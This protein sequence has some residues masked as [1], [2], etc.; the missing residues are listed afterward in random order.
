MDQT[1]R[2]LI[3]LFKLWG[4][5]KFFHPYL[6]YRN[7][8]WDG[9]LI[10]AIPK[11]KAADDAHAFAEAVG[12]NGDVSSFV[13]PGGV[14]VRF[15]GQAVMHP[16]GRQLQR[17]GLLPD[18]EVHPTIQGLREG[19]DEVLLAA[20]DTIERRLAAAESG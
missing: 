11:V 2:R 15:T 6:A 4:A 18:V 12:A 3:T 17:V 1:Q 14:T 9:A 5:V 19:R 8:D 10:A 7:I 16:D 13:L 20:I